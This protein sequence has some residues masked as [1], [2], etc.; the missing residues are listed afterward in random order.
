M[1]TSNPA[2]KNQPWHSHGTARI[3][4]GHVSKHGIVGQHMTTMDI[5]QVPLTSPKSS[6]AYHIAIYYNWLLSIPYVHP[7]FPISRTSLFLVDF[8]GTSARDIFIHFLPWDQV[9]HKWPEIESMYHE[10]RLWNL[11]IAGGQTRFF[12]QKQIG[13]MRIVEMEDEQIHVPQQA[14]QFW[15]V[16]K[17]FYT[18]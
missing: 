3:P 12:Q 16:Q 11:E 5:G 7:H 14:V 13:G 6:T 2:S 4:A 18:I 9:Q 8:E 1:G 10:E 17:S 15:S